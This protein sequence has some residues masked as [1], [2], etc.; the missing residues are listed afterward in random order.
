VRAVVATAVLGALLTAAALSDVRVRRV[1]NRLNATVLVAGLLLARPWPPAFAS[2][3]DSLG[4]V[5]VGLMIWLPMYLL[6]LIGA[7]DVKLLAASGAW[8]GLAGTVSA[9]IA[10]ALAG[11]LLGLVWIVARQGAGA[12]MMAVTHAFRVPSLLQLRPL[13]RRERVPYAVAIAVGV[14]MVWLRSVGLFVLHPRG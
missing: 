12:A 3:G 9:S 7:G 4:G 5:V 13:D 10:T 11:G 14:S 8:L 2:L 6:R 1:S